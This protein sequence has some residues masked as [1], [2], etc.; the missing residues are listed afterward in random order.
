MLAANGLLQQL[1]DGFGAL[2]GTT[3][4]GPYWPRILRQE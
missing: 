3:L 1:R 4:Q 2:R